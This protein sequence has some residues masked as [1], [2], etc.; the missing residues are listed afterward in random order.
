MAAKR[1]P[2]LV[3]HAVADSEGYAYSRFE[4]RCTVLLTGT[5]FHGFVGAADAGSVGSWIDT[6]DMLL[7]RV[8]A[9]QQTLT[10]DQATSVRCLEHGQIVASC[11]KDIRNRGE[12]CRGLR[13]FR[14]SPKSALA[15]PLSQAALARRLKATRSCILRL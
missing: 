11:V 4:I 7:K 12:S 14:P 9:I 15:P 10:I 8:A 1:T 2:H 13:R 6:G 3:N 5:V